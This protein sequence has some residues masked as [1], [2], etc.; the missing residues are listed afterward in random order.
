MRSGY[1]YLLL[2]LIAL[3][4]TGCPPL[5]EYKLIEY[6]TLSDEAINC[7]PYLDGQSYSFI[8]SEGQEVSFLASRTREMQTDYY[9][10]CTEVRSESDLSILTPDYPIFS[11]NV[12]IRKSDTTQYSCLIWAG[13][14]SFWLP[15]TIQIDFGHTYFDSIQIG[16]NW[17]REVYKIGNNWRDGIPEGQILADS[18]YY[19]TSHG[20][21]KILMSNREFYEISN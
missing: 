2:G 15:F 16:Q 7:S 1:T 20:I 5:C 14:S 21:L 17:Y 9:D 10:E 8:H 19:N 13:G 11:C 4:L 12:G 3:I 18:I 6:G